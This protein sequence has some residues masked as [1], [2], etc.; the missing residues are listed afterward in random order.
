MRLAFEILKNVGTEQQTVD[1]LEIAMWKSCILAGPENIQLNSGDYV[2]NKLKTELLS[3]LNRVQFNCTLNYSYEK[4]A[5]ESLINKLIDLGALDIALRIST[6]FNYKHKVRLCQ[7]LSFFTL[8]RYRP[9]RQL[10]M[11]E[12]FSF[13]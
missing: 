13:T 2:F 7:E 3:G 10:T 11:F 12:I 6:I 1:T 8:T 4:N 9:I 5:A